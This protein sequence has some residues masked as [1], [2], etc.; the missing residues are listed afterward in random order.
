M[1]RLV[2]MLLLTGDP[3]SNIRYCIIVFTCVIYFVAGTRISLAQ[4]EWVAETADY[5]ADDNWAS[6]FVPDAEQARVSNG[7]VAILSDVAPELAGLRI[8][9][10]EHTG[11]GTVELRNGAELFVNG[12]VRVG[13]SDFNALTGFGHLSIERGAELIALT[14]TSGGDPNSEIVLG[15]GG[16]SG[17]AKLSVDEL[18]T[19]S[20]N[21]RIV[22][23]NVEFNPLFLDFTSEHT[24]IAEITEAD[25]ATIQVL[26]EANLNDSAVHVEFNG[27][28]PSFGDSWTL[29]DGFIVN[30][31]FAEVTATGLPP[32]AG[33]F[34][35]YG[36][37]GDNGEVVD[38]SIGTRLTLS[39]DRSSGSVSLQNRAVSESVSIGGYAIEGIDGADS[40]AST[41]LSPESS[42]DLGEIY[43]FTPT[44]IGEVGPAVEFEYEAGSETIVGQVEFAGAH[45]NIVLLVD[46]ETGAAALQNQ[47][48]FDVEMDGYL[49]S[50]S[51]GSLDLDAWT[52]FQE[53]GDADWTPANPT[54]SHL[55]ELNLN[56]ALSLG[57]QSNPIS[58][59]APFDFD[60]D[61]VQQDLAFEFHLVDVGTVA[62]VV[63]YGTLDIPVGSPFDCNGDGSVDGADL[64]CILASGGP[65]ALGGLLDATGLLP[66]DLDG[67]G[68]VGF[69]DFLVLSAN[70]GSDV[71]SYAD[72]DIDGS[73][74]VGF[75][76]FLV[77]S[78]NFGRSSAATQSVPEPSSFLLFGFS[79]LGLFRMRRSRCT[80][81]KS[82]HVASP[83]PAWQQQFQLTIGLLALLT[84]AVAFDDAEAQTLTPVK[85]IAVSDNSDRDMI[86]AD[87]DSGP[88]DDEGDIVA[89]ERRDIA[90][91]NRQVRTFVE[92]DLSSITAAEVANPNWSAKFLIDF[93]TRLNTANDMEV[94]VGRVLDS[95]HPATEEGLVA[96]DAWTTEAG[97]LPLFE[98]GRSGGES[99]D[100]EF[101]EDRLVIVENAKTDPFGTREIDVTSIVAGW[102]NGTFD[103]NGFS[104][105]GGHDEFQGA[106]LAN[107]RLV[108]G[109]PGDFDGNG[110][111]DF[112]DFLILGANFASHLD[113]PVTAG[114]IDFDGDVDLDDFGQFKS[115]F[116]SSAQGALQVSSVPEPTGTLLAFMAIVGCLRLRS[117]RKSSKRS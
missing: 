112:A 27:Y 79:I 65:D 75:P 93:V 21:L 48:V 69:P 38:L 80:A 22:G 67:S 97:S 89:R 88:L 85:Q 76:D 6:G 91:D 44:A 110:T 29:V 70:F 106:G 14:M 35:S 66:G 78:A 39:V 115:V 72:G 26:D 20:R 68:D 10:L 11:N 33:V 103:N 41:T 46:P 96:G 1:T 109:I 57:A 101:V 28:T 15:A 102:V 8:G 54:R 7:G 81:T 95:S 61:G 42:I 94:V 55:A 111:V 86:A 50:S 16:N 59:G 83:A 92:F 9:Q 3:M 105:A 113:G 30:G 51:S 63:E 12:L 13:G 17:V 100:P 4:V 36:E 74:S 31:E 108:V 32:G 77:L 53:S 23:P 34:L 73:G 82:C 99:T 24:L 104:L 71:D 40:S 5:N 60:A 84:V 18:A 47:S 25:H 98:W 117:A 116:A 56:S 62:G 87:I 90:Q 45:N 107:A 49:I 64:A 58:I 52:S 2:C 37:G 43:Q 114:D 19:F